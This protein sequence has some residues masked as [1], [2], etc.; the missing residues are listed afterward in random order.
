MRA[1][2]AAALVVV[3]TVLT[4]VAAAAVT[5][6]QIVE[7]SRAGV[8][9]AIILAIIDRDQTIFTLSPD[10]LIALKRDGV[11]DAVVMAM[12][13][14]GRSE[15]EAAARAQ[16]DSNAA[17]LASLSTEPE[18]VIVGHGPEPPDLTRVY[19]G[20]VVPYLPYAGA[21]TGVPLVIGVAL[22]GGPTGPHRRDQRVV[23]PDLH[24]SPVDVHRA[25]AAVPPP[26][27]AHGIFFDNGGGPAR[28]I[29]FPK[30]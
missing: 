30:D 1:I 8:S 15:S 20:Q 28:G 27:S 7:L 24:G 29:F 26:T 19:P 22:P 9:E 23:Q 25:P 21:G 12:L 13:K 14:S 4:P 17:L 5:V 6:D 2:V 3:G 16:S 11:S 10:E 18:V